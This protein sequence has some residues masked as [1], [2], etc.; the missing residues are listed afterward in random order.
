MTEKTVKETSTISLPDVDEAELMKDVNV[1]FL[2]PDHADPSKPVQPFIILP[3]SAFFDQE[4]GDVIFNKL[5]KAPVKDYQVLLRL[6]KLWAT[7]NNISKELVKIRNRLA[8]IAWF[9][10]TDFT[11][12]T[13]EALSDEEYQK[14]SKT[15][16]ELINKYI[17][18]K[19]IILEPL[20]S[21]HLDLNNPDWHAKAFLEWAWL[22]ADDLDKLQTF[23]IVHI[24]YEEEPAAE[25]DHQQAEEVDKSNHQQA[26]DDILIP[27]ETEENDN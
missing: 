14:K 26:D 7:I 1:P 4:L 3:A 11:A 13:P 20:W 9:T 17:F 2:S 12:L 24:S 19:A 27:N 6:S 25:V 23:D 15:F 10:E 21:L 22:S 18:S 16:W 5:M 8:T